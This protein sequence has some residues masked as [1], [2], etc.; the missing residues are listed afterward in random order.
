MANMAT[1]K[2][3]RVWS[4]IAA[5]FLL[6]LIQ[7]ISSSSSPHDTPSSQ[8]L[9]NDIRR[10]SGSPDRPVVAGPPQKRSSNGITII[11]SNRCQEALWPAV[12]TQAGTGAGIGGFMLEP[13]TSR[14]LTVGDDWAGRVW[15][16]TNCT[17]NANGTASSQGSGPACSTGDCGAVMSCKGVV[18]FCNRSERL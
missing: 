15:G 2:S 3:K 1:S 6:S 5:L 9:A 12:D 16:R 4:I 11:V 8:L 17:F 14:N 18:S 7:P 10:R 13:G